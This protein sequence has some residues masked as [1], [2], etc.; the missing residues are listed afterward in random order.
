M[1]DRS[2]CVKILPTTIG[3]VPISKLTCFGL[4]IYTAL[5]VHHETQKGNF[6]YF[7]GSYFSSSSYK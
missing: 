1:L 2:E 3:E 5:S 6:T 7:K 4:G